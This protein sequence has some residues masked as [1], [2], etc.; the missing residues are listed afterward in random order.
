MDN[1]ILEVLEEIRDIM[2][3]MDRKLDNIEEDVSEIRTC[4]STILGH[5][6]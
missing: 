3:K 6:E 5:V 1:E 2:R 4:V